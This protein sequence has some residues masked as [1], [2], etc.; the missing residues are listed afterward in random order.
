MTRMCPSFIDEVTPPGEKKVFGRLEEV[1]DDWLVIHSLDVAPSNHNKRTEI[2]FLVVMPDVGLLCVEVKSH[3]RILFDGRRWFPSSITRSPFKQAQDAKHALI[4]R[5]RKIRGLP[6][7][8]RLPFPVGHV[9]IF[10]ESP[11]DAS[12]QVGINPSELIDAR[13]LDAMRTWE[14]FRDKL[15]SSLVSSLR[16]EGIRPLTEPLS[17][18]EIQRIAEECLPIRKRKVQNSDELA[19]A[20]R[21]LLAKLR[22]QQRPVVRLSELNPRL[23]VTGPA[24]TGKTLI[25][26]ELAKRLAESGQRVGLL[27]F[28]SLLGDW[29]HDELADHPNVVAGTAYKT[30]SRM[31]GVSVDRDR[32]ADGAYWN[33]DLPEAYLDKMTSPDF[34]EDYVLDVLMVDEAQDLL[35]KTMLW[36]CL[37]Q[38]VR[39]GEQKGAWLVFGDFSNQAIADADDLPEKVERLKASAFPAHWELRENCRNLS[40]IGKT[41]A[42]LLGTANLYDG[43]MR[44]G[45]DPANRKYLPYSDSSSQRKVVED[46]I[47]ALLAEGF[48]ADDII[49]LSF[50]AE[51]D[52]LGQRLKD[53]GGKFCP[54]AK[55]VAGSICYANIN[56]FKGMERKV[57][58]ITDVDRLHDRQHER[59]RLFVGATRATDRLR[60]AL[61]SE[62]AE[63]L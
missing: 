62:A 61:T 19:A 30:L 59:P 20:E 27:C 47:A 14:E 31:T 40:L 60:I 15:K 36:E 46:E 53:E 33:T 44:A 37:M 3:Q 11:F 26:V 54:V 55:P 42:Y 10:S 52:S 45:E 63:V 32:A 8:G 17:E 6:D 2:D 34:A 38:L 23:L 4:R 21:T 58:I 9:C 51:R 28:N 5:F 29:L 25:A 48:R 35:P 41:A 7:N 1:E 12:D 18:D 16:N 22:E 24:G 49:L 13:Q 43:Y 56:A 39:G 50:C 57:V